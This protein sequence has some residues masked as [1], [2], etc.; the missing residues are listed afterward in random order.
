L[1]RKLNQIIYLYAVVLLC[2]GSA[3]AQFER[4]VIDEIRVRGNVITEESLVL[5]QCGLDVGTRLQPDDPATAIRNLYS[6]RLFSDIKLYAEQNEADGF[7]VIIQVVEHPQMSDVAF[8]GNKVL[9]SKKLKKE[10]GFIRGE[11]ITPQD[12]VRAEQSVLEAYR[13]KGHNL[14]KVVV[15]MGPRDDE[16]QQQ[17]VFQVEEGPKVNLKKITFE[18]N[19]AFKDS[20]L[21]KQMEETKQDGW[22]FGG[23]KYSAK[24]YEADKEKVLEWYRENGYRE[25]EVVSDSLYFDASGKDLFVQIRLHEGPLYTFGDVTWEGNE[26]MPDVAFHSL[27]VAKKGQVYSSERATKSIED[28]RNA[29]LDIGYLGANIGKTEHPQ[30]GNIVDIKYFV[31]ENDPWKV[32]EIIIAGNTKT[33]D[34]V[35]RRELWIEPGEVFAR[36]KIERSVRNLMQLNYFNTV[37]PD[38]RTNEETSE[39]DLVLQ[40]DERQTGTASLGAGFSERDKLVGTVGLQIPNFMG[41]GQQVDFQWEFGTQRETFVLGFTEPWMLNTP[42]S[43]STQLFRTTS[44]FISDFDQRSQGGTVRVGRRLQWPDFTSVSVGYTLSEVKFINFQDSSR[45]GDPALRDNVTSSVSFSFQRDSRDLPIFPT[46][47]SVFTYRPEIA[48]GLLQGNVNFHKHDFTASF[49]YPVFWKFALN[50]RSTLG[51]VVGYG[52]TVLPFSE[53]Y[54]P[55]GVDLFDRTMLR[56]Y[57]DQSVGPR[58]FNGSAIGGNTQLL[59]NAE[60]SIPIAPNQ[61]YGLLFADAGNA[62]DNRNKISMFDLRR[63]VGFGIRIVAPLLGIMGFDFAWGLDR[64]LVDGQ[65]TG[66]VTHFQFGP[67][68]F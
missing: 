66:M 30:E 21:R 41:N 23:G 53:L 17:L 52:N 4:P 67:Q 42:T 57:E 11:V 22:W 51:L 58:S 59:F 26:T 33:K 7:V 45:I 65:P 32:R 63:S 19:E 48:G 40:V 62:W 56:G 8:E 36:S 34:R 14:A 29:Y 28:L 27:I 37:E 31:D 54:T 38:I 3:Y 49:N 12:I 61:F 13:E 46:G 44:R 16:G 9:K 15:E 10:V 43:L 25:A 60:L 50:V 64:E 5:F 24:T 68:F 47:G 1:N 55:G 18:G 20:K 2:A 6:L 35:I 39:L